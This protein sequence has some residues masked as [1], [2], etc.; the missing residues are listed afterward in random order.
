MIR[1]P[2]PRRRPMAVKVADTSL[3]RPTRPALQLHWS[4]LILA[5]LMVLGG[6]LVVVVV[7]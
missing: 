6:A 1:Q 2:P 7:R 4:W 3:R 5:I